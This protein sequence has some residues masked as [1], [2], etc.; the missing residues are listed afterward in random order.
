MKIRTDFVTNSSS[1]SFVVEIALKTVDEREYRTAIS[2]D[3]GGGNGS[4]NI[5][6]KANSL[7]QLTQVDTLLRYIRDAVEVTTDVGDWDEEESDCTDQEIFLQPLK[8]FVQ[9]VTDG[10]KQLSDISTVTLQ[11]KWTAWGEAA[12]NFGWNIA[13]H[14]P[15]LPELAQKVCDSVGDVKEDAKKALIAYLDKFKLNK[16]FESEWGVKFPTRFMGSSAKAT[17]EWRTLAD[18]VEEFASMLVNDQLPGNDYAI[19]TTVVDIQNKKVSQNA[20]IVLCDLEEMLEDSD[21]Y[22]DEEDEY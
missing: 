13:E 16:A 12:Y 6:C 15:E 17:I 14:A 19:E 11:R 22:E 9:E 3:D 20:K 2:P 4:A 10:V 1:S 18:D 8:K 7:L 5:K 21:E